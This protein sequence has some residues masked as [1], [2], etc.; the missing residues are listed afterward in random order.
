MSLKILFLYPLIFLSLYAG[1]VSSYVNIG[2][3][4]SAVDSQRGSGFG[5]SYGAF[6]VWKSGVFAAFD[7]GYAQ[8]DIDNDTVNNY[9]GDLKLGYSYRDVALYLIGS[10]IEQSCF[11]TESAGF[12]YGGGIEYI[13]FKHIGFGFDYKVYSMV[14]SKREYDFE[15]RKGYLKILF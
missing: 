1:S 4:S 3:N 14:S 10:G 8:A 13:P 15:V 5:I 9:G 11:G 2:A 12:G 6:V 7:F